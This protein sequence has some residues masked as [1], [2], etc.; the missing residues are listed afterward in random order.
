MCLAYDL[1]RKGRISVTYPH[2]SRDLITRIDSTQAGFTPNEFEY[3]ALGQRT[4]ITDSTGTTYFVWDGIR[5]THE[6]TVGVRSSEA[7][8]CSSRTSAQSPYGAP[9]GYGRRSTDLRPWLLSDALDGADGQ[10]RGAETARLHELSP[11]PL[12]F[13]STAGRAHYKRRAALR[14]QEGT[15]G[16]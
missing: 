14:L 10:L 3:N 9:R 2:N 16:T 12:T 11:F 15:Q 1:G 13:T 8:S 6:H 5:I 7:D 4:R